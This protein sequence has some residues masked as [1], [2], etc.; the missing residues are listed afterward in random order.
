MKPLSVVIITF[1]EEKNIGRC[2]DSVQEVADEIIVLDS[3]SQDHTAEIAKSKGAKIHQQ[4]FQGYGRQKNDALD[5]C[6]H[7][8]VLSLDADEALSKPLV[9]AI[10]AAKKSDGIDAYSMNRCTNYCGKYIRHGS[11][12]PDRKV[13]LFNR[14]MAKWKNSAIH[15]KVEVFPEAR[16]KHL[17]GDILHYSFNNITEH[18][19][20]NNKFSTISAQTLFATGKRTSLFKVIVNPLWAFFHSYFLRLGFL[21]GWLGFI[22]AINIAHLTFL[23]HAKLMTLQAGNR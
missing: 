21:D 22:I 13:R 16:I 15:E 20:Q 19:A 9:E 10:L 7:D 5:Y 11:W 2:L 23:K 6:S 4:E 1:N 3:F 17:D 14:K 18:V 12:Y 8:M